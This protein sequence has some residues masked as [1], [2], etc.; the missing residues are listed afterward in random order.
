MRKYVEFAR[1]CELQRK[2]HPP[3]VST[4]RNSRDKYSYPHSPAS[5]ENPAE[6][7]RE[8]VG[9]KPHRSASWGLSRMERSGAH[10]GRNTW[11]I[12]SPTKINQYSFLQIGG[13]IALVRLLPCIKRFKTLFPV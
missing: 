7:S 5:T 13:T 1:S 9:C 2:D 8:S 11:T 4:G 6:A 12:L 10:K 3:A